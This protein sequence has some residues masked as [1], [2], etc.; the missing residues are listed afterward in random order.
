MITEP[1]DFRVDLMQCLDDPLC[2]VSLRRIFLRLLQ[3]HFHDTINHFDYLR[4]RIGCLKWSPSGGRDAIDIALSGTDSLQ[5]GSNGPSIRLSFG[6]MTFKKIVQDNYAAVSEDNSN[7]AYVLLAETN[8]IISHSAATADLA[9]AMGESTAAML[10][11]FRRAVMTKTRLKAFELVSLTP[12]TPQKT[13]PT[14]DF[15]V[16]VTAALV[17]EYGVQVHEESHRLKQ[18]AIE[19]QAGVTTL[20]T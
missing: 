5:E 14:P 12:P 20:T 10:F 17:F 1:E 8:I 16:D 4:P 19:Y 13:E 15:K 9:L 6:N 18:F 3:F 11:G 7:T 2:M